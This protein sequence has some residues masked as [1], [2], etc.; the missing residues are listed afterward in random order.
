ME[1]E[2]VLLKDGIEDGTVLQRN[3]IDGEVFQK[4]GTEYGT[5]L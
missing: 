5:V 3:R 1:G 4:S 2:I